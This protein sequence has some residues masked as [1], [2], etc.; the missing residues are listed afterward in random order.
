MLES[1]FGGLHKKQRLASSDN[2]GEYNK[3]EEYI[4][5]LNYNAIYY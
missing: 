4:A 3:Y 1:M 2:N 5:T